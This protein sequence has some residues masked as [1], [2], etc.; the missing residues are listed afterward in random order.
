MG[1]DWEEILGAEGDEIQDAYD[2]QVNKME[3]YLTE[4]GK[5]SIDNVERNKVKIDFEEKWK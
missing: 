1:I 2:K 4:L 5:N 3:E